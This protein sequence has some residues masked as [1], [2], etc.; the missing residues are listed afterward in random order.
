[1]KDLTE[2]AKANGVKTKVIKKIEIKFISIKDSTL[3]EQKDPDKIFSGANIKGR[4]I[5]KYD[6]SNF[7]VTIAFDNHW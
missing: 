4:P 5:W 6:L 3:R 1:M 7:I 2:Y